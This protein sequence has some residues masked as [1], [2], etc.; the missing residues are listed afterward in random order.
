MCR[1]EMLLSSGGNGVFGTS[2]TGYGSTTR[3]LS[4]GP[5]YEFCVLP[6]FESARSM[7]NFTSSAVSGSP[8]GN[9]TPRRGEQRRDRLRSHGV[10]LRLGLRNPW[11]R[12]D[13]AAAVA[14]ATKITTMSR[15]RPAEHR[16]HAERGPR[17]DASAGELLRADPDEAELAM[18]GILAV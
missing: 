15:S 11:R 5:R 1:R 10:D 3:T 12:V 16:L 7:G 8:V 17:R 18:P 14:G 13:L 4:V 6:L 2:S 9:F